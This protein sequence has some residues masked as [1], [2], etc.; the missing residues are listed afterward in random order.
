MVRQVV[1]EAKVII[2]VISLRQ[3]E[4]KPWRHLPRFIASCTSMPASA[5]VLTMRDYGELEDHVIASRVA[6]VK[7]L[8]WPLASGNAAKG[9]VFVCS[10]KV[11]SKMQEMGSF[12]AKSKALPEWDSFWAPDRAEVCYS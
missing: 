10:A 3:Y 1:R 8:F 4:F 2:P 9:S 5:V 11:G 6:S 7:S 12:L